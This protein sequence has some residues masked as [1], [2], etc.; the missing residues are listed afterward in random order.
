LRELRDIRF[1]YAFASA[2]HRWKRG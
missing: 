1:G 2:I